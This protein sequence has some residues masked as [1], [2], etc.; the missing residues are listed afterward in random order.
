MPWEH[1]H[2]ITTTLAPDNLV[3]R[4]N[5]LSAEGLGGRRVRIR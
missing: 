4:L 5:H 3:R 2:A 1:T